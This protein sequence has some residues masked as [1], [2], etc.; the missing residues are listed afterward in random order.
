MKSRKYTE[1]QLIEILRS[2][3]KKNISKIDLDSN[4]DLPGSMTIIRYFGS[5][6]RALKIAGLQ[7]GIKT[8]RK[9][10]INNNLIKVG[11]KE[12]NLEEKYKDDFVF[13]SKEEMWN[14]YNNHSKDDCLNE[15]VL[16]FMKFLREY[17]K[18][19]D[20]FFP[21]RLC[22]DQ[23]EEIFGQ[24]K[25]SVGHMSSSSQIG[26]I[27]IKSHFKSFWKASVGRNKSPI[28]IFR[29][30]DINT[31]RLLK[32]RF[33][34]NN[35]IN[36]KYVFNNEI[37]ETTELF[38]VS[39]KQIRRAF[40]VNKYVISLFKPLLAKYIYER[41]GF[42]GMKVWDCCFGYAGRMLGFV[43]SFKNGIY[44]G[45]DPNKELYEEMCKLIEILKIKDRINI[46]CKPIEEMRMENNSIDL[47]FTCPPYFNNETYCCDE[48]Q[49][50][51]RYLNYNDWVQGFLKILLEKYYNSL[52]VGG[53]CIIVLD[54][55]NV[56][57]CK[58]L[59]NEIGFQ[60]CE[61][62]EIKN[63]KTHLTG[64]NNFEKVIVFSKIY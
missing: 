21:E 8:G 1:G 40:E 28:E 10:R 14:Y 58:N 15:I 42:D 27:L 57:I 56:S 3:N 55:K 46:V 2:L 48:K 4:P 19:N 12:F 32:Y 30:D 24:I 41:Y 29:T 23:Y 62:F 53:K 39:F 59:A 6:S 61:E 54:N 25:N 52:R 13:F 51:L 26:N 38:D 44:Y 49:S 20:W 37:V 7:P 47:C 63:T 34:I 43:S 35:S 17:D 9:I 22:N 50:N 36:Y 64:K 33:G 60:F 18:I 5:W 45:N 31:I 11:W 16:P